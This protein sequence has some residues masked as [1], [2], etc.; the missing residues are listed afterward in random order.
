MRMGL[1]EFD[2]DKIKFSPRRKGISRHGDGVPSKFSNVT[3]FTKPVP[4]PAV[5]S[6]SCQMGMC[7]I[8]VAV[9]VLGSGEPPNTLI[10][11]PF[12]ALLMK[13]FLTEMLATMSVSPAYY[14]ILEVLKTC[15]SY[16]KS[17]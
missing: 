13:M 17:E 1:S 7:D 15:V 10:R 11:A 16:L 8:N 14:N 9:N 6:T 5:L 4:P 3:F 2:T 12:W